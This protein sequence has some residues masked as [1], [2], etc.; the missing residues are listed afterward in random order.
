[1]TLEATEL[2]HAILR[3]RKGG[4]GKTRLLKIAYLAE[5]FYKRLSGERLTPSD[6]VFWQFGPY[7]REYDKILDSRAFIVELKDNADIVA[8]SDSFEHTHGNK[9]RRGFLLWR[10][11]A[12]ARGYP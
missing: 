1:M 7:L 4:M 2:L 9:P 12:T 6:W 11:L 3:R 5:V 8:A 10:Y